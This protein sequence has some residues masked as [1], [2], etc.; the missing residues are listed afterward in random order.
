MDRL[1]EQSE[2]LNSEFS[3]IFDYGPLEVVSVLLQAGLY[4]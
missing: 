3:R 4:V 1:L 2:A